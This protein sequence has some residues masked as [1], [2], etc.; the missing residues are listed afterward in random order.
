MGGPALLNSINVYGKSGVE[1]LKSLVFTP[2]Y[3]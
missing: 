3:L 2:L 1:L